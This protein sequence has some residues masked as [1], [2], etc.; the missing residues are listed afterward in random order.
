[1]Y[2]RQ[3]L[4][5]RKNIKIKF[6]NEYFKNIVKLFKW[7]FVERIA[8]RVDNFIFNLIV[9]RMG[10]LEYSVHVIL[11]QIANIYE[12]FI[13]GFGDGIT[14]SV[15]IASGTNDNTYMKKVKNV[16]K[17]LI[18]YCSFILPFI[19][20]II[21]IIIMSI[22]L[23]DIELQRIFIS[24][25]PLFLLGCYI[26][27]TATYYFSIL[28][29]IRDFK[30]LARRNILSSIIKITVATLLAFTYLGIVGVWIGY[31]VYG[32]CQKSL[33]KNR[34]ENLMMESR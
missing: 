16:A 33:S 3:C 21:A 26:S 2:K 31:L 32:I 34:Y 8:S 17:K 25:L 18:K 4:Y 23:R 13:Q 5:S 14:I 9:A 24:V 22:S 30:F 12:S 27:M 19:V 28:R 15:G 6:V 11:I 20:L 29:G 1:M 10:N 7:N